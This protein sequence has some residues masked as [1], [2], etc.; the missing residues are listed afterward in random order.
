MTD[1]RRTSWTRGGATLE[2]VSACAHCGEPAT[3]VTI[4]VG[5]VQAEIDL[6]DEHLDRLLRGAR[7]VPED[8]RGSR[9]F[10][11]GTYPS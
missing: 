6:C 5:E 4:E 7:P 8:D 9:P 3:V 2:L 1:R 11:S 10:G